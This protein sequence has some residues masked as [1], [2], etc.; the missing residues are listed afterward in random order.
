MG[1][2]VNMNLR[3]D[4]D[5]KNSTEKLFESFGITMTDA[6][7]IFLHK[8]IMDGGLPFEMKQAHF[9]AET[10]SAIEETRQI[11]DGNISAKAYTSARE[12][13]QELEMEYP[14]LF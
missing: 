9:N 4:S 11:I 10:E 13:F 14:I 5:V 12:L 2:T 3:L 8:S 7:N 6:I 1:K